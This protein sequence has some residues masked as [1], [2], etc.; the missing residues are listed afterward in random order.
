MKVDEGI[1]LLFMP[2]SPGIYIALV[3]KNADDIENEQVL[4]EKDLNATD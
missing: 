2:H 3:L 4:G 1:R